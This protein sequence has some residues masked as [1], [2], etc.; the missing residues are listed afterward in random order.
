MGLTLSLPCAVTKQNWDFNKPGPGPSP[1]LTG[2]GVES[3]FPTPRP[4]DGASSDV[5]G[6]LS[7]W[8]G[9]GRGLSGDPDLVHLPGAEIRPHPDTARPKDHGTYRTPM[10]FRPEPMAMTFTKGLHTAAQTPH[11][12]ISADDQHRQIWAWTPPRKRATAV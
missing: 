1:S 7:G 9:G 4:P 10:A 5:K 12:E 8:P 3:F 2:S 6:H 11:L